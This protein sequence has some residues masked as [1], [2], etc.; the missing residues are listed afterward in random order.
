MTLLIRELRSSDFDD[1][2]GYF[3]RFFD[4]AEKDPSF[5]IPIDFVKPSVGDELEWFAGMYKKMEGGDAVVMVAEIDSRVVGMCEVTRRS[6][7]SPVSH[8]G[9]LGL[10]VGKDYR[11]KGVGAALLQETLQR[12]KGR[13]EII[14]LAVFTT[15]EAAKRIYLRCG[16]KTIGVRKHAVKRGD[17]YFDEDLMQLEI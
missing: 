9:D 16:F 3:Y 14:E 15:N 7:G 17:R 6:P 11:G 5:G 1:I 8:R 12:C 4:E 10:A 2:L 13:F